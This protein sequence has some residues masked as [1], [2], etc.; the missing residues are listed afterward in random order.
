MGPSTGLGALQ[1]ALRPFTPLPPP[2]RV[3]PVA[4]AML[5]LNGGKPATTSRGEKEV[6]CKPRA[7]GSYKAL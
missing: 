1:Q 2:N 3:S 5:V 6:I 4:K 7:G